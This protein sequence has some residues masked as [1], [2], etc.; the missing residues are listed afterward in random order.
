MQI[1]IHDGAKE[2]LRQLIIDAI[3]KASA[4]NGHPTDFKLLFEADRLGVRALPADVVMPLTKFVGD[5]PIF[6]LL[7]LLLLV[8]LSQIEKLPD[9]T[10]LISL[11]PF[12][13]LGAI[14]DE[15]VQQLEQ[16]PHLYT[17]SLSLP[18][19]MVRQYKAKG[20]QAIVGSSIA[21]VGSWHDESKIFPTEKREAALPPN[22]LTSALA[23]GAPASPP[24]SLHLHLTIQGVV[25]DNFPTAPLDLASSSLKSFFGLCLATG[26]CVKSSFSGGVY[27]YNRGFRVCGNSEPW[28]HVTDHGLDRP[29]LE[30]L[31]RLEF[32]SS[33]FFGPEEQLRRI[34]GLIDASPEYPPL[35][36]AGRWLFDSYANH[37]SVMSLMQ[38]AIVLEVL[39][40]GGAK[41]DE[42]GLTTLLSN[43]CAYMLA[44]STAERDQLLDAFREIYKTRSKIV[45]TGTSRLSSDEQ[46]QR[47]QLWDMCHRVVRHEI[48]A[49]Y[50]SQTQTEAKLGLTA[51][52][53]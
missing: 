14:A 18:E 23:L 30:L 29:D 21:L 48:K 4:K 27:L 34:V 26:V 20:W 24:D 44:E 19:P 1:K 52:K 32:E 25:S 41:G 2:R 10:P 16:I 11:E 3:S 50:G 15:F 7:Y 43:R 6:T 12:Q 40:G 42:I 5:R 46:R 17:F 37:D 49:V 22:K 9:A 38:A 8:K 51:P 13:D 33:S 36:L 47:W 28:E 35:V 45:H 53:R 31:R 39:L